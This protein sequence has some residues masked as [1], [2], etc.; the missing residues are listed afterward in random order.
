[1]RN[2]LYVKTMW[3]YPEHFDV[4]VIG[5]GHAG[6]EAAHA[7]AKAG[8]R[9]L[10]LSMNLDTI[11][12]MSCNPAVG[13][14]GKGHLV[15][16][17]DALGGLMG[18]VTDETGIQFRMLNRT[19]GPAVWSPRAQADKAAYA[20][21]MRH[22]LEQTPNLFLMQG[23]VEDLLV[24]NDKVSG[25]TTKEGVRYSAKALI[26][27]SGTF[28]KGLIHIGEFNTSAGRAGDQPSIGLSHSLSKLGL[29]LGRLKTGTPPRV[30]R[31]SIDFS[32]TEEQ[33]GEDDVFFSCDA[34][35]EKRLTQVS[36][37]I[38]YTTEQTR[39]IVLAN[40]SKSLMYSGKL[41]PGV[42][43]PRYCPSIEDKMVRFSDK[44]RH[45]VFLEPEGLTT[46]EFYVNGISTSL[47]FDVQYAYVRTIIGLENAE[48]ARPGYAI[49]YDYVEC[50]HLDSS[51]AVKHI[52]GLYLAG[53]IN[54]TTG[55]EEAAAQG[56]MAGI[57][58]ANK[59]LGRP[60]LILKRSEAYIGVMIDDLITKGI[61]EPY[62]IFTSRAEYRLLLRQ[63]NAEF[64]LR[65][66]GYQVGLVDEE[67][68]RK[69]LQKQNL[70]ASEIE[71]LSKAFLQING[72][73][74]SLLQLLARPECS[75]STL[76][77][78]YPNHFVDHGEINLQLELHAKYEGY[79]KRQ[80]D[81]VARAANTEDV[82][83]PSSLDY[84]DIKGLRK[85]AMQK[86]SHAR[87]VNLGQAS[88]I[89]RRFAR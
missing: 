62:R 51:L 5:G 84:F 16:E 18:K 56:L 7:A 85:E 1:M 13:G 71:R 46:E 76:V 82:A 22:C 78:Q 70:L 20:L 58:A 87:P 14:V 37:Y 36:C 73:G 67:R 55:Y 17:I 68:Y 4:I 3:N 44:E 66:Y 30:Y 10:L 47:P 53:Q 54:G 2:F 38:T 15:R 45:Q 29:K 49:E 79:L 77:E 48:I 11:A 89:S 50:G 63:D 42:V 40:L 12:K 59:I 41:E 88:R 52:E 25:V 83:L 75:Y 81:E 8:L 23:T 27:T 80:E 72:K 9:T 43:G 60:P 34:P 35:K 57:N 19:K 21:K 26:I 24:E 64:R 32:K 39:D 31:R 65:E 69:F 74:C 33:A 61:D 86:L 6:C 28:L